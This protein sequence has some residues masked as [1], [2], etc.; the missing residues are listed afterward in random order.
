MKVF[1]SEGKHVKT[2]PV[3]Y[4]DL[5]LKR[6]ESATRKRL[7]DEERLELETELLLLSLKKY[8]REF[9]VVSKLTGV[10]FVK[11]KFGEDY[12]VAV[13]E[14]KKVKR[15]KEIYLLCKEKSE[16]TVYQ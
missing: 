7:S 15:S 3:K 10:E 8:E 16:S 4:A 13:F 1:N 9:I 2:V 5:D 11:S 14:G 12:Y 6:F